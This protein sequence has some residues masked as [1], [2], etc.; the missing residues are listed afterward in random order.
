MLFYSLRKTLSPDVNLVVIDTTLGKGFFQCYSSG[1]LEHY[2][3]FD[4]FHVVFIETEMKR[5]NPILVVT[6]KS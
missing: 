1:Q 6:V 2:D 5:G 3:V 4:R